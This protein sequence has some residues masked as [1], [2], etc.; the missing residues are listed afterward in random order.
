[1]E[2]N[3]S[4]TKHLFWFV[5]TREAARLLGNHSMDEVRQIVIEENLYQ[6]K[7]DSRLINEFG[8]TRKRLE[9]LFVMRSISM[10]ILLQGFMSLLRWS[11][12]KMI[13]PKTLLT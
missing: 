8:C 12:E 5:E 7:S 2:Y 9:Y 11:L 6:Q 3:A 13:L 10:M 4:V 1:M